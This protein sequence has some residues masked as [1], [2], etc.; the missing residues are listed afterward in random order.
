[1]KQNI[2]RIILFLI[3]VECSFVANAILSA[4]SEAANAR[5]LGLSTVRLVMFGG[6]LFF[7]LIAFVLLVISVWRKPQF[8][9]WEISLRGFFASRK[10]TAIIGFT[11]GAI[12]WAMTELAIYGGVAQEPVVRAVLLRLQPLLIGGAL[13]SIELLLLILSWNWIENKVKPWQNKELIGIL[14]L[15]VMLILGGIVQ[16]RGGL[17]FQIE[18]AETGVFRHPGAPITSVQIVVSIGIVFFAGKWIWPKIAN[19]RMWLFL[20]AK[21]SR[22]N[23]F[24]GFLIWAIAFGA[25]MSAP[26][27]QSWFVDGP[28]APNFSF[29]PN[30]DAY[31]Y[32][33][34]GH[35]LLAGSG[36]QHPQWGTMVLRP[37]YSSILALFHW[38]GG[39][40]YED[41]IWL[42]VAVLAIIP[43]LVFRLT[44][45]LHHRLSGSLA[46][47]LIIFRE[48]NSISLADTITVSHAKLLMADL[49]VTLGF[50]LVLL[51]IVK[52]MQN[53]G[54][55][56]LPLLVGGLIGFFLLVRLEAA[57]LLVLPI[58]SMNYFVPHNT[59]KWLQGIGLLILGFGIFLAPWVWRNWQ[60]TKTFYLVSPEYEQQIIERIIGMQ[61]I[62][63][64]PETG[65]GFGAG[66]MKKSA[67]AG[68]DRAFDTDEQTWTTH[69]KILN[70]YFN[71]QLQAIMYLPMSPRLLLGVTT[72]GVTQ[73]TYEFASQC[74][75][76]ESY[77][78]SL[79]YW[80]NGWDGK[81]VRQSVI[82][83]GGLLLVF[84]SGIVTL[85]RN[86]KLIG[87][88]PVI[89]G[90]TY[91]LFL[92][93]LGRSGGRWLLEV[94]WVTAVLVSIGTVALFEGLANWMSGKT[95]PK[96][97]NIIQHQISGSQKRTVLV[98]GLILLVGLTIPLS[99][100]LIP[101]QYT[102][103]GIDEHLDRLLSDQSDFLNETDKARLSTLLTEEGVETW[104]GRALYPR[105]FESGDGMDGLGGIYKRPFSRMEFFLV[106]TGNHWTTIAQPEP[107][108]DFLHGVDVLLVGQE[109]HY[110]FDIQFAAVYDGG[111]NPTI[112]LWGE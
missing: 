104:Y 59:I 27:K 33:S 20:N 67:S 2:S 97:P 77:V 82:S 46:A 14:L 101:N 57:A 71:S 54:V 42:Q 111:D 6:A 78:R 94:D 56:W 109:A 93:I 23:L 58:L 105:F 98:A 90:I 26:L 81:L 5:F 1:M 29:S 7:A 102:Q 63:R 75:S 88:L 32:D 45:I 30:S 22:L 106:G 16:A 69:E 10:A 52:W 39:L 38:I 99:E 12:A 96:Y 110:S 108:Q 89:F 35:S 51:L 11:L 13:I 66:L 85:W 74:C 19:G 3:G 49:P 84:A 95:S 79:P 28:R 44:S 41:I 112:V 100:Q 87:L 91:F 70:H 9:N 4:P 18:T 64:I 8:Q 60:Y 62:E 47:S 68:I 43:V 80:W 83:M 107:V 76:S 48:Y 72:V 92:A 86:K 40:G 34:V 55:R 103:S 53:P 21:N 17:G 50:V 36:F 25:W 37:M 15:W 24:L 31:L 61:P 73:Q 65:V